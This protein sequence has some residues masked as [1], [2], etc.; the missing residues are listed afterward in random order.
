L[1]FRGKP[2]ICG[3]LAFR[4]VP[5]VSTADAT[6]LVNTGDGLNQLE[7]S[8]E[9]GVAK[10]PPPPLILSSRYGTN[11][12]DRAQFVKDP[13]LSIEDNRYV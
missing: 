1:P 8:K 7:H 12:V 4:G 10:P 5:I 9:Q 13:G 6:L 2:S 3:V 11:L